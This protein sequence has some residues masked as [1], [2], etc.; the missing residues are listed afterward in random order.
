MAIKSTATYTLQAQTGGKGFGSRSSSADVSATMRWAT[1]AYIVDGTETTGDTINFGMLPVGVIVVPDL[2]K[3][4]S[5][6]IGGTGAVTKIGDTLDDDRHSATS[7]AVASAVSTVVTPVNAQV[8]TPVAVAY[9]GEAITGVL[10]FATAITTGKKI[11][12]RV[13]YLTVI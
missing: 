8:V 13:P 12:L 7:V 2:M 3:I 4:S 5:D 11:T 10:T 6:G 1:L 9:G